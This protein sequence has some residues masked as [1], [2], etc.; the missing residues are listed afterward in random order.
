MRC[1]MYEMPARGKVQSSSRGPGALVD[2]GGSEV[3][4]MDEL[5]AIS[6]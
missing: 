2:P 3:K 4:G 6:G 5:L 1:R